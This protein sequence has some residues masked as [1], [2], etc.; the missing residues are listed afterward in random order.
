MELPKELLEKIGTRAEF[1][2]NPVAYLKGVTV[3]LHA[4]GYNDREISEFKSAF[5]EKHSDVRWS[6]DGGFIQYCEKYWKI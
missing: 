1:Y 2:M 3:T 6:Y 5:Q 4:L